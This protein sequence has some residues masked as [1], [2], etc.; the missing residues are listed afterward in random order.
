MAP[1][2]RQKDTDQAKTSFWS[3]PFFISGGP[4]HKVADS[5]NDI[6]ATVALPDLE[7]KDIALALEKNRLLMQGRTKQDRQ[8][9]AQVPA[10]AERNARTRIRS[11]ILLCAVKL[12]A[13]HVTRQ[14][15]FLQ[16]TL[17]KQTHVWAPR[18]DGTYSAQTA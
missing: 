3:S 1:W 4:A 16:I 12:D 5:G 14:N 15:G 18:I 6:T 9:E 2:R 10:Y 17:P 7:P 11:A 13:A 8:G